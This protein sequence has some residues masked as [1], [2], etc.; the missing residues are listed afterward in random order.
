LLGASSI[1]SP[2]C[3]RLVLQM[4]I[5]ELLESVWLSW[6]VKAQ[7]GWDDRCCQVWRSLGGRRP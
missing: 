6:V 1:L 4:H 7:L 3:T 5:G 2:F